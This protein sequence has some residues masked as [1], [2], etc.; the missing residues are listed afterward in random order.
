MAEWKWNCKG[1]TEME[2][3]KKRVNVAMKLSMILNMTK[4]Y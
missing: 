1:E 2:G 3:E 4:K